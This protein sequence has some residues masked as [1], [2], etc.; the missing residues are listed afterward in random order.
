MVERE[1]KKM[2]LTPPCDKIPSNKGA[3]T[4]SG[5]WV[6]SIT[7]IVGSRVGLHVKMTMSL[8]KKTK[9]SNMLK[10]SNIPMDLLGRRHKL[11]EET[12]GISDIWLCKNQIDELLNEP[13]LEWTSVSIGEA[14]SQNLAYYQREMIGVCTK[15]GLPPQ[16]CQ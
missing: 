4:R 12:H 11:I 9:I 2:L 8:I 13:T 14:I 3:T 6:A 7:P 1:T 10:M 15:E 16:F 5:F